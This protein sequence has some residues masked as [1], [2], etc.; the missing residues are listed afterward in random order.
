MKRNHHYVWRHYLDAWSTDGKVSCLRVGKVF[1]KATK[2]VAVEEDFYRVRDL[3]DI[4]LQVILQFCNTPTAPRLR[5]VHNQFV[6]GIVTAQRL[7][8][9]VTA[10]MASRRELRE[11][12]DEIANTQENYHAA[13]ERSFIEHLGRL[14][15]GE[16]EFLSDVESRIDLVC[17][18]AAQS[19]RTKRLRDAL[20]QVE[21]EVAGRP[22]FAMLSAQRI[23]PFLSHILSNN[24]GHSLVSDH[25]RQ[26]LTLLR[27]A[28]A[29]EFVTSDHPS[30]NLAATPGRLPERLDLFYPVSPAFALRLELQ[31]KGP[32]LALVDLPPDDVDRYN[33]RIH[34]SAHEMTFARSASILHDLLPR[35]P[36]R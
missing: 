13:T 12:D 20:L 6:A 2:N 1:R 25:A 4:D 22:E 28:S 19:V 29:K 16:I 21:S 11:I 10:R 30:V 18:L 23:W 32:V 15:R 3:S 36:A 8:R 27:S 14:R 26:R 35:E 7:R 31:G 17:Y 5:E 9:L 33:Q 24:V 34:S